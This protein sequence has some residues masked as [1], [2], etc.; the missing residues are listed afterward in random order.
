MASLRARL[1]EFLSPL[2]KRLVRRMQDDFV[3]KA[4][5]K[6]ADTAALRNQLA[7]RFETIHG[8]I[9]CAHQPLELYLLADAILGSALPG[10]VV[11][12]GCFKGGSTA[13]LSLAVKAAGRALYV[14]DSFEGLPA[15][16]AVE[17][18]HRLVTGDTTSYSQGDYRGGLEEVKAN[19]G[20]WGAIEVCTFVKGF[21]SDT[22]PG[23]DVRPALIFM[24][25]DLIESARTCVKE[26]WPRLHPGGRF[27]THEA[28][29]DT[30]LRGLL[31]PS[32]WHATFR[33]CPPLLLGAGFGHG[34][35]A[36]HLAYFVR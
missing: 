36:E 15:P 34:P 5:G 17:A 7:S 9:S 18:T 28:G 30:F 27:Y 26:F 14:C 21:F 10:P 25:V 20:T 23:L 33:S 2:A 35:D 3:A 13:K 24:D 8:K 12:L 19:V 4:T 6:G 29:V 31:D 22:L 32:W 11:E 16:A 1:A